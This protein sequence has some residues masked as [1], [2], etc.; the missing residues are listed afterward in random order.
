MVG[1]ASQM[2]AEIIAEEVPERFAEILRRLDRAAPKDSTHIV[3]NARLARK[4]DAVIDTLFTFSGVA[5]PLATCS[6]GTF[7]LE[8]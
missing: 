3:F 8:Q 6:G 7:S 4:K 2:Y 5:L 1:P